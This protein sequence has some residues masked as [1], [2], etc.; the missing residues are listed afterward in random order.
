MGGFGDHADF[1][2]SW[3]VGGG[4]GWRSAGGMHGETAIGLSG[5]GG[6]GRVSVVD[7]EDASLVVETLG[8]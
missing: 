7:V 8:R 2:G 4:D 5:E 6:A 1:D 3:F